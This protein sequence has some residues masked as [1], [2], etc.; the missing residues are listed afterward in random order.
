MLETC[1]SYVFDI[2]SPLICEVLLI[3]IFKNT[4]ICGKN[5]GISYESYLYSDNLCP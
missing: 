2:E 3:V 1:I 5:T 4:F